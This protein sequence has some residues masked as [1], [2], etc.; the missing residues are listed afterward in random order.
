LVLFRPKRRNNRAKGYL[1]VAFLQMWE[2][3]GGFNDAIFSSE[4]GNSLFSF[5]QRLKHN[6]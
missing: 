2:Y 5:S 1:P 3:A 6:A 4:Y